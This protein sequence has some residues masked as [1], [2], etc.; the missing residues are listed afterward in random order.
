MFLRELGKRRAPGYSRGRLLQR[1]CAV[2]ALGA[3]ILN[4]ERVSASPGGLVETDCWGHML[5]SAS[6]GGGEARGEACPGDAGAVV[7]RQHLEK[8]CLE[9]E[10]PSRKMDALG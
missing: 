4:F 5:I 6:V 7:Q 3:W 9:R 8:H 2:G 1:T 10:P